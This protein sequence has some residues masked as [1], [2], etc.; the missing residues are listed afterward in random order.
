MRH[1]I[2]LRKATRLLLNPNKISVF[3]QW[4]LPI[5]KTGGLKGV[6]HA[7]RFLVTFT[8]IKQNYQLWCETTDRLTDEDKQ[9]IEKRITEFSYKPLI[10]IVMPVYNVDELWLCKAIDSIREQI[11]PHWEFCI[12]DDHSS[13]PH[14]RKVLEK[15]QKIDP[16]IKVIFRETTGH[17]SEAS[18]SALALAEG[19]FIALLDHDD[20]LR[21]HSLYCMVDELNRHPDADLLYSDEDKI[22]ANGNR[23]EPHF[24]SDW[25]IDLFYSIN[26]ITHL[27]VI[28]TSLVKSIGG[29]RKGYEGSQ[30]YDLFC[31]LTEQTQASKIRHIPYILYHWR[32]IPGSTALK[33]G[34]KNYA[35]DA[36][37]KALS[38]HLKR[39][40][41]DANAIEGSPPLH[42][43]QYALPVH[44]PKVS[45]ILPV[46]NHSELP[47]AWVKEL[48]RKTGYPTSQLEIR[49][50]YSATLPEKLFYELK[51]IREIQ[52]QIIVSS[53]SESLSAMLNQGASE[54]QGSI[55]AF[56]SPG[57]R[58]ISQDWF[59]EMV[60]HALRPDV[61]AVS[62]KVYF[63]NDTIRTSGYILST[64]GALGYAFRGQ[65]RFLP[66]E[67]GR[68]VCHQVFLAAPVDGMVLRKEVFQ[69]TGGFDSALFPRT[70]FDIDFCLKLRKYGYH[71]V[72]TPF[73]EMYQ[74]SPPS[75]EL[76]SVSREETDTFIHR[77]KD[78]LVRDPYYNINLNLKP[79]SYSPS[80]S[81]RFEKAWKTKRL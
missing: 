54:A 72:W 51:L 37:R 73:A 4:L 70:Y 29:F 71:V 15:Y 75:Y 69:Q 32:A 38:D 13:K 48:I 30:D 50:I 21:P 64:E 7:V 66:G 61:G 40:G 74:Y 31:R 65:S 57:L 9:A 81:P 25:N 42:R 67:L 80:F 55:L 76:S 26:L 78:Q 18:N 20:E 17:I 22:D 79:L 41:I 47:N 11:Y 44:L 5:W 45:I 52:I 2:V 23:Y 1:W 14:I 53:D 49:V 43:I 8:Y 24:K 27:A 12:A 58:F 63:P 19:E 68:S 6:L 10:S 60:S 35:V 3:F 28:R 39:R 34:E 46:R 59:Q 33:S 36:A 77:W 62:P 16:R 56:M